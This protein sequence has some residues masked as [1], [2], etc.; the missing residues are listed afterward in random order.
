M[1][2]R[3]NRK[4]HSKTRRQKGGGIFSKPIRSNKNVNVRKFM[5]SKPIESLPAKS[6]M[7]YYTTRRKL[8]ER[9]RELAGLNAIGAGA[10]ATS[11]S[12]SSS[13]SRFESNYTEQQKRKLQEEIS[14][15]RK[16]LNAFDNPEFEVQFGLQAFPK[17]KFG[18]VNLGLNPNGTRTEV[19]DGIRAIE[20]FT[21]NISP[22]KGLV[23]PFGSSGPQY[24]V[25]E[26]KLL[27]EIY[28]LRA[29]AFPEEYGYINGEPSEGLNDLL[30]GIFPSSYKKRNGKKISTVEAHA[31]TEAILWIPPMHCDPIPNT[32]SNNNL[33]FCLYFY[34][35]EELEKG[36][37]MV[38]FYRFTPDPT[39]ISSCS[40]NV[41]KLN[42][43]NNVA[44]IVGVATFERF[45]K[46]QMASKLLTEVLNFYSMVNLNNP[47]AAASVT[48]SGK[49]GNV[50]YNTNLNG[51][52][53]FWLYYDR[54]KPHLG[55][56][57]SSFGF[58]EL[59][60]KETDPELKEVYLGRDFF[61]KKAIENKWAK[62]REEAKEEHRK[63]TYQE[64]EFVDEGDFVRWNREKRE[65]IFNNYAHLGFYN[66]KIKYTDD[67]GIQ[68]E[69]NKVLEDYIEDVKKETR[70]NQLRL[71]NKTS[72]ATS[73]SVNTNNNSNNISI[74]IE[75]LERYK[76][77]I[78]NR[79]RSLK[80][81][82]IMLISME[83]KE[84]LNTLTREEETEAL[85]F[86][87]ENVQM[88]LS[89]AEWVYRMNKILRQ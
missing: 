34:T 50:K 19:K 85:K 6:Q 35:A 10:S 63:I 69:R 37:Q 81:N 83:L 74:R 59:T 25:F 61:I 66:K 48:I 58:K 45:Q 46:M 77:D 17:G 71:E 52:D 5:E 65:Y 57:Y 4:R 76:D 86:M 54:T 30:L 21:F 70:S 47:G 42:S 33:T 84:E 82:Q 3:T 27:R 44:E 51:I 41:C 49:A 43:G 36:K 28:E 26:K 64:L 15:L 89:S 79:W 18:T 13:S 55:K 56:F 8:Q 75:A 12:T 68:R 2:T 72:T 1:K 23:S 78:F 60:E 40:V 73:S 11:T 67:K 38:A 32:I 88:V 7:N 24:S 20:H 31:N 39:L 87:R 80:P 16:K 14:S 53:Y 29:Q 62:F 9:E 22:D